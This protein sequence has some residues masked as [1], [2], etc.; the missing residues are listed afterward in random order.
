MSLKV[1]LEG[2]DISMVAGSLVGL[3]T[4]PSSREFGKMSQRMGRGPPKQSTTSNRWPFVILRLKHIISAEP[5]WGGCSLR[6]L[7]RRLP[8]VWL[9]PI[10]SETMSIQQVT[11]TYTHTNIQ[12]N[13]IKQTNKQT[14]RQTDKQTNMLSI[15]IHL[16]HGEHWGR[17][18]NIR[19]NQKS[20]KI[21]LFDIS[22]FLCWCLDNV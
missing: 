17:K 19:R 15:Y 3:P 12:T 13:T 5:G 8:H 14:N 6:V 4:S 1:W 20:F 18:T 10:F 2:S 16:Y 7:Q 11:Q 21:S 9:F 22:G